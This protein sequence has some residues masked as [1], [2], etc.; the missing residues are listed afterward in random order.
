M[1]PTIVIQK[2]ADGLD[3]KTNHLGQVQAADAFVEFVSSSAF[4]NISSS[5]V[6]D[7]ILA[8]DA[9]PQMYLDSA[10]D[11]VKGI[12]RQELYLPSILGFTYRDW[13]PGGTNLW[14]FIPTALRLKKPGWSFDVLPAIWHDGKWKLSFWDAT[15]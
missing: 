11:L 14:V 8:K 4:A 7:Y 15:E 5:Q 3:F 12:V 10:E 9:T 1:V 13:G 6:S 2:Y